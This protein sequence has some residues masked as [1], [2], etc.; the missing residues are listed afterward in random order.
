MG[1]KI[2]RWIDESRRSGAS[3]TLYA[4]LDSNDRF[5]GPG[6]FPDY[7]KSP[8][9]F[10]KSPG[11]GLYKEVRIPKRQERP[12]SPGMR[13]ASYNKAHEPLPERKA[14][15]PPIHTPQFQAKPG[16]IV[17]HV[18]PLMSPRQTYVAEYSGDFSGSPQSAPLAS[19]RQLR[20]ISNEDSV[21]QASLH[22]FN[23]TALPRRD[24][25]IS[26]S[27]QLAATPAL[28]PLDSREDQ[29]RTTLSES[30]QDVLAQFSGEPMTDHNCDGNVRSVFVSTM[31]HVASD[32]EDLCATYALFYGEQHPQNLM[33]SLTY[34]QLTETARKR[35]P[36][37]QAALARR[38]ELMGIISALRKIV[39]QPLRRECIHVCVSSAYI[40]K[41]WG[42]WIPNW[43]ANGWP[44]DSDADSSLGDSNSSRYNSMRA[45]SQSSSI[46]TP[47]SA[48]PDTDLNASPSSRSR[49]YRSGE[50]EIRSL[51][52]QRSVP[53][54]YQAYVNGSSNVLSTPK[55]PKQT[56]RTRRGALMNDSD[57]FN[58]SFDSPNATSD[59]ASPMSSGR[60]RK[61]RRLVDEDLLREL[62]LLRIQLAEADQRGGACV[63]LYLIERAYN[64]ATSLHSHRT[65]CAIQRPSSQASMRPNHP[66]TQR[67]V[68]ELST[69]S[70]PQTPLMDRVRP[71]GSENARSVSQQDYA[72]RV[73]S[74]YRPQMPSYTDD[75]APMDYRTPQ[76]F[77][78]ALSQSTLQ[79][80]TSPLIVSPN[81]LRADSF[82]P[83]QLTTPQRSFS[84]QSGSQSTLGPSVQSPYAM[85]AQARD[86]PRSASLPP[87]SQFP[88]K[89]YPMPY[90]T[91]TPALIPLQSLPPV[92]ATNGN[93]TNSALQK[94]DK[95]FGDKQRTTPSEARETASVHSSEMS[96]SGR[97]KLARWTSKMFKRPDLP[98]D[99]V[100]GIQTP[101]TA[102]MP[103]PRTDFSQTPRMN[104]MR[105][106]SAMDPSSR[107]LPMS[108]N[109]PFASSTPAP[110]SAPAATNANAFVTG[111][112][113]VGNAL[114]IVVNSKTDAMQSMYPTSSQTQRMP[115][116]ATA[117]PT[118]SI[119]PPATI[120]RNGNP[121]GNRLQFNATKALPAEP[122]T[123]SPSVPPAQP[124]VQPKPAPKLRSYSSQPNL[125]KKG[126]QKSTHA[127]S[128]DLDLEIGWKARTP[129]RRNR[130]ATNP[131][132]PVSAGVTRGQ[133]WLESEQRS[134]RK[135]SSSRP[136]SPSVSEHDPLSF[137]HAKSLPASSPY[138]RSRGRLPS[139]TYAS[140]GAQHDSH[141]LADSDSN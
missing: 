35:A 87:T 120:L 117:P 3:P 119:A 36:L 114:G 4:A 43:E 9:Q 101:S 71:A 92:P 67:S 62:A 7:G 60:S 131:P 129:P 112:Q 111:T 106:P 74:L 80:N 52:A 133:A 30:Q 42:I 25:R 53:S 79:G 65:R 22:H 95:Q 49:S 15:P 89:P 2:H 124:R 84:A 86:P 24:A 96:K 46:R 68:S 70:R 122:G 137:G 132:I 41:A 40:A 34:K 61:V 78:P 107:W 76:I 94:H 38:V 138:L 19:S 90:T 45:S 28:P 27:K 91:A 13:Q 26:Y 5:P 44:G 29:D 104:G 54:T 20:Q 64:P 17:P 21:V 108:P 135:P 48:Y 128:G 123:N 81:G 83:S 18:S 16:D 12:K 110:N 47:S 33:A 88:Q 69:R 139:R 115:S 8:S 31:M 56:P 134:S 77:S 66:R 11:M 97:F 72:A 58:S 126:Q 75:N 10:R 103:T 73:A 51:R 32:R 50:G 82:E 1:D 59:S 37:N 125:R 55:T 100:L 57:S 6:T 14:R 116:S 93:L 109:V 99:P 98:S 121:H 136:M 105:T 127:S 23:K 63:H 102:V 130:N 141:S 118:P 39:V 85:P 140:R 113:R